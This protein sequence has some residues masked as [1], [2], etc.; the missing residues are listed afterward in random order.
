M[1]AFQY[2]DIIFIVGRYIRKTI[3]KKKR[4]CI[5]NNKKKAKNGEI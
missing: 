1:K 2:G 3:K 5:F 4:F